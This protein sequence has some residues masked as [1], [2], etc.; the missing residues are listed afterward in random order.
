MSLNPTDPTKRNHTRKFDSK[1]LTPKRRKE[2]F[3]WQKLF[4]PNNY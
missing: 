3:H 1:T 4:F 2:K